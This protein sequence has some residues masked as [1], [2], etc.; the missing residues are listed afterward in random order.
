MNNILEKIKNSELKVEKLQI[1]K[2]GEN[3]CV[4]ELTGMQYLDIIS[5]VKSGDSFYNYAIIDSVYDENNQERLFTLDN[6]DIVE[7]LGISEY[8]LLIKTINKLNGWDNAGV[9]NRKNLTKTN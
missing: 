9:S 3:I 7:K 5:K 6:M 4:R 1:K 2:W 8:T